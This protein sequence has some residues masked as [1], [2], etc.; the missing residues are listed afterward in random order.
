MRR[1]WKSAMLFLLF[2]LIA[3]EPKTP[4]VEEL[5]DNGTIEQGDIMLFPKSEYGYIGDPMPLYN[6]GVMNVFYL[7]DERRGSIGFH[8]VALLQTTNF[9]EWDDIGTVIPYVN[10]ISSQD[11]AIGTGS[12]IQDSEGLY[13]AFYTGHN[14]T[15]EMEYFEKIQH[16]TSEDM[17]EWTKHPDAGFYGGVNDFRDPYIFYHEE[18][19][20]YWM[21]ITTRD[22]SG[23]VI[24]RYSSTD[25]WTWKNEGVFYRNTDGNYNMECPTLIEYNG[26]YYLSFS[27]QGSGNER[28]VHYRYTDNLDD[29]FITPEN[30]TFDGWGFYAGR[31]EYFQE[32]LLLQGWVATKTLAI[33]QGD[34]MWGGHLITHELIQREDGQLD[35]KLL[36][37]IDTLL[38]HEVQYD[39]VSSNT[40]QTP[41]GFTMD[42]AVGYEYVLFEDLLERP[43]KMSF[44]VQL[45]ET[46]QFGLTFNAY[47]TEFGDLNIL[48]NVESN[49]LEFYKVDV[50]RITSSNPEISIP[51]DFSQ[52]LELDC[53]L[54]TEGD[55]LILYVN[56]QMALTSR[57]YNMSDSPF[58][59]FTM[60][61]E[62]TIT[63][64]HFY[65]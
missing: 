62:A 22:Y 17:I 24:R 47:E 32:R 60:G 58:G 25:L 11:L 35:V 20:E 15:G 3:C 38:S 51:F 55:I 21:L 41:S 54:V 2:V 26:Y 18:S 48:F 40:T 46:S 27:A 14:G 52:T 10:S 5:P 8:P 30:D 45:S 37:E 23:G 9:Y 50:N 1:Y 65:E 19:E 56:D 36:T 49:R 33:D 53:V 7:L 59:F 63:N 57:A 28:V 44:T 61:S 43:T 12:V 16:A 39:V 13:H 34:Y 31:I 6:N 4:P 42:K 29:G 64:I